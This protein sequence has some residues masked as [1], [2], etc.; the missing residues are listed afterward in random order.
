MSLMLAIVAHAADEE[1]SRS[2]SFASLRHLPSHAKARSTAHLRGW[3]R[4]PVVSSVRLMMSRFQSPFPASALRPL[5]FLRHLRNGW[6]LVLL[7]D[8][9][10]AFA[11]LPGQR[12]RECR[13]FG[14]AI[15]WACGLILI[16]FAALSRFCP[17]AAIASWACVLASPKYRAR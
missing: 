16:L 10:T 9:P 8:L 14:Y 7:V 12:T 4:K 17:I 2:Q 15:A 13:W 11:P 3:T 5:T 1:V 6:F